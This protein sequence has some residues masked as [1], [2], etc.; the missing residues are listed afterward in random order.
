MSTPDVILNEI[1]DLGLGV[2]DIEPIS[3]DKKDKEEDKED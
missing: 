3:E 2:L 1:G